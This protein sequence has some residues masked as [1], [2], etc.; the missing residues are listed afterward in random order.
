MSVASEANT[1][2]SL[3]SGGAPEVSEHD[4]ASQM[5]EVPI[6]PVSDKSTFP[7]LSYFSGTPT[8]RTV[9]LLGVM[10]GAVLCFGAVCLLSKP[11]PAPSE[12]QVYVCDNGWS[13][14]DG[15]GK[16]YKRFPAASFYE[17]HYKCRQMKAQL[18][19][20][21]NSGENRFLTE[22]ASG[23]KYVW[24]GLHVPDPTTSPG[25]RTEEQWIDG[26]PLTYVAKWHSGVGSC[27]SLIGESKFYSEGNWM[28]EPCTT[29]Y[30]FICAKP[31]TRLSA[32]HDP[33]MEVLQLLVLASIIVGTIFFV[34]NA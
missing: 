19:S 9:F 30:D 4:S 24:I 10:L 17:A 20:V 16:C 1:S 22:L 6:A 2:F 25:Q 23:R 21:Q 27:V 11:S 18:T 31:S 7:H 15:N 3:V 26:A 13:Y 8:R 14:F 33:R 29:A 28:P 34:F 5:G 32:K 12:V